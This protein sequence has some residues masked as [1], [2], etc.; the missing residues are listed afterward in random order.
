MFFKRLNIPN[1]Q[2]SWNLQIL[3]SKQKTRSLPL[4][5]QRRQ[6]QQIAEYEEPVCKMETIE[7][8]S[9]RNSMRVW[10]F[11]RAMCVC[12]C[13][14]GQ[15]HS[16]GSFGGNESPR[17]PM[18]EQGC[19]RGEGTKCEADITPFVMKGLGEGS[20]IK[21][22]C[23]CRVSVDYKER[24]KLTKRKSQQLIGG[25]TGD[26]VEKE[27][28]FVRKQT[29]RGPRKDTNKAQERWIFFL[30]KERR[31]ISSSASPRR[32]LLGIIIFF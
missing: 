21:S 31:N 3:F 8:Y 15:D 28:R 16:R 26:C 17:R 13:V 11:S 1:E 2:N 10:D 29:D 20:Q 32:N 18:E 25:C 24:A 27:P 30:E 14:T 9:N 12:A 22:R 19:R 23:R 4:S 6:N 5:V 7:D